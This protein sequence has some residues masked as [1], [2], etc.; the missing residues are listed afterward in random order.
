M[1][2]VSQTTSATNCERNWSTFSSIHALQYEVENEDKLRKI[3]EKIEANFDLINLD[4]IFQE[5]SLSH[6]IEER[7][8]PL[9]N[10][11]QNT[12]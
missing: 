1:K 3:Q 11:V 7:E 5:D 2:V 9:L 10:G 6:W 8:N 12:E 4:Y